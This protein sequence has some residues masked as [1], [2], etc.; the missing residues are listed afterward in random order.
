MARSR[1]K[2]I[3]NLFWGVA[4]GFVSALSSGSTNARNF[5]GVGTQATTVLRIRGEALG[6][7]DAA[8]APGSS[9]LIQYGVIQVP[10]GSTTTVLY[11]PADDSNA[12]WLL[13]GIMAVGYEEMVVDAI[14]IA[15]LEM[16]RHTIDN[17]AMRRLRPDVELQ[18][19]VSNVAIV[20]TP[21]V[22]FLYGMRVLQ[23]F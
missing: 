2:K 11:S 16:A 20:G 5:T 3:D 6:Y 19:A 17:K 8:Q 7:F 1:V 15:G 14:A 4:S 23:G 22:N 10:E 21:A 12:P 13:Y 18:L 9:C